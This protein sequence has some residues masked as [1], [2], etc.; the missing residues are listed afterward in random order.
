MAAGLSRGILIGKP[1][2][3][4]WVNSF[5]FAKMERNSSHEFKQLKFRKTCSGDGFFRQAKEFRRACRLALRD[6]LSLEGINT[7]ARYLSINNNMSKIH[8][9][10]SLHLEGIEDEQIDILK[11]VLTSYEVISLLKE[12]FLR[13]DLIY[14]GE[15]WELVERKEMRSWQVSFYLARTV[16]ILT[17][18]N[19]YCLPKCESE[20][21]T[22]FEKDG[23]VM[24]VNLSAAGSNFHSLSYQ[25]ETR[26]AP[27]TPKSLENDFFVLVDSRKVPLK[28]FLDRRYPFEKKANPDWGDKYSVECG[29]E[30]ALHV[31]TGDIH[32]IASKTIK[33][34]VIDKTTRRIVQLEHLRPF[35][36]SDGLSAT[37]YPAVFEYHFHPDYLEPTFSSAD[38]FARVEAVKK[39]RIPKFLPHMVINLERKGKIYI[40]KT[41]NIAD[42]E[43][44]I[45]IGN[46]LGVNSDKPEIMKEWRK[47]LREYFNI[48]D[49]GFSEDGELEE[50]SLISRDIR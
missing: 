2:W 3:G 30:I 21:G 36:D 35:R 9:T 28:E 6:N 20:D 22:L 37:E 10:S 47:Y 19:L 25:V 8:D 32:I 23:K 40:P 26:G 18:S 33:A 41:N 4:L 24:G 5:V 50:F 1:I 17:H 38:V 13:H 29:A 27:D 34:T 39:G 49:V 46:R 14:Q 7:H 11:K 48:I 42:L 44:I 16:L 12:Q 45:E 15:K 43:R 31:R